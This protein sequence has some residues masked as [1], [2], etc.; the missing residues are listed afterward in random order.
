MHPV[1]TDWFKGAIYV[2]PD[3]NV[4]LSCVAIH[5]E[6]LAPMDMSTTL[7]LHNSLAQ[8]HAPELPVTGHTTATDIYSLGL[9]LSS[10]LSVLKAKYE[11]TLFPFDGES[12]L[13]KMID[14]CNKPLPNE[15]SSAS[16]LMR[17]LSQFNPIVQEGDNFTAQ[18]SLVVDP[19]PEGVAE[20]WRLVPVARRDYGYVTQ[21]VD[22]VYL[23]TAPISGT[24]EHPLRRLSFE[25]CC[26]DQGAEYTSMF[27]FS[28]YLSYDA[29]MQTY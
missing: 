5:R 1:L 22:V 17:T 23:R 10:I 19:L 13:Q 26:H 7:Q 18:P 11:G 28:K 15:R 25:V 12:L 4:T 9:V 20:R 21:N 16:E 24:D 29:N 8:W 3:G 2:S 27:L 6:H 14:Q